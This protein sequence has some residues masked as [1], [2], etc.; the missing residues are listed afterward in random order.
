MSSEG[1]LGA[2]E[3]PATTLRILATHDDELCHFS[4]GKLAT[5]KPR[6]LIGFGVQKSREL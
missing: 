3:V 1:G 6:V 5:V 4:P 2:P